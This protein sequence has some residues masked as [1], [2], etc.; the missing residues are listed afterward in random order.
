M[1]RATSITSFMVM[2]PLC[3]M[4]FSFLRSRDGS[5]RAL[6]RRAAAEGI[7]STLQTRFCTVSL[8]VTF[9]PFQ[10]VVPLAISSATFLGD[11]PRGPH[12]GA[13]DATAP[14]SPPTTRTIRT[15]M[16]AGSNLGGMFRC[17]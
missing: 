13:R 12:L 3:L 1:V 8:Q 16:A 9:W 2:L 5:F 10:S 7:T 14:A 4:F 11:R 17:V 15:T 6:T